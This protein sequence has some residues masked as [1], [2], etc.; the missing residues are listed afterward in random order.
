MPPSIGVTQDGPLNTGII[1]YLLQ[2]TLLKLKTTTKLVNIGPF[3]FL[4][5]LKWMALRIILVAV[6]LTE[7]H[8]QSSYMCYSK[9]NVCLEY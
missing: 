8:I 2:I 7:Q 3:N 1:Y 5:W 9:T 6:S 4:C